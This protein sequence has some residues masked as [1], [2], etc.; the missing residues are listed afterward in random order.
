[1]S[2]T[3]ASDDQEIHADALALRPNLREL[4]LVLYRASFRPEVLKRFRR[5]PPIQVMRV[6]KNGAADAIT[7]WIQYGMY[8]TVILRNGR[9]QSFDV[10]TP[11]LSVSGATA[12]HATMQDVD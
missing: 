3:H 4:H 7:P 5:A 6:R 10:L 2:C 1:M 9:A 8:R 12:A 11:Q